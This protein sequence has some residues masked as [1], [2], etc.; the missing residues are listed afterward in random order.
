MFLQ[1]K[2]QEILALALA[3]DNGNKTF[4]K[5]PMAL[6]IAEST[7]DRYAN[8]ALAHLTNDIYIVPLTAK[9]ISR[10][11]PV[12][13]WALNY[14]AV[15]HLLANRTNNSELPYTLM[16]ALT[17]FR[18]KNP[19]N[20]EAMG[21]IS[22]VEV[23]N[24]VFATEFDLIFALIAIEHIFKVNKLINESKTTTTSTDK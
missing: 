19:G 4:E 3:L 10:I 21:N 13:L 9:S 6:N 14:I 8:N 16:S 1:P 12:E 11:T 20:D 7:V 24:V 17:N 5:N 23:T 15:K 2:D 22:L 18:E